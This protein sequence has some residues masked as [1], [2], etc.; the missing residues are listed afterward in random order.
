M[1]Q[2]KP[3]ELEKEL[4]QLALENSDID[5]IWVYGSLADGT[6]TAI[7]DID[8]AIAFYHFLDDPL[9]L[10]ARPD[11]LASEWT[12]KL[13]QFKRKISIVDIN[14][15]PIPLAWEVINSNCIIYEQKNNRRFIEEKRIFSRME[16]D[17]TWHRKIYG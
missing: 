5:V 8:I 4:R 9:E 13:C 6:E 17:V 12:K 2:I 10:L 1:R 16:L 15:I 14:K 11:I 7:S 3:I